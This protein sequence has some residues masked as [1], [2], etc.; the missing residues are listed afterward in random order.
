VVESHSRDM[1]HL[2]VIFFALISGVFVVVSAPEKLKSKRQKAQGSCAHRFTRNKA[3][4]KLNLR[5]ICQKY[6]TG[7]NDSRGL[8][9]ERALSS[10]DSAAAA[11]GN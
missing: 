6:T 8:L 9:A 5:V 7:C 2:A 1:T 4:D 11:S 3:Q 10:P